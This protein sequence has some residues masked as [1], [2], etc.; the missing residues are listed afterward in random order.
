MFFILYVFLIRALILPLLFVRGQ[1]Y[2]TV[3]RTNNSAYMK[4]LFNDNCCGQFY[5]KT[6][7][8]FKEK[9]SKGIYL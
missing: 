7:N 6:I 4:S 5:F 9:N 3:P 2:T 1:S 8:F